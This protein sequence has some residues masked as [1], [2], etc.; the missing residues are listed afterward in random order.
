[1]RPATA[2][3]YAAPAGLSPP[4]RIADLATAAMGA[5]LLFAY[6]QAWVFP[7][8]GEGAVDGGIV[9]LLY[10]P[11]YAAGLALIATAPGS[12]AKGLARQPFLL[13]LLLVAALSIGW[14]IAPDQSGRRVFALVCTTLGGAALAARY[15]WE[16]FAELTAGVFGALALGSFAVAV[17]LPGVGVM[18]EIFPGAWRGLWVEKNA[19]GGNMALGVVFMAGAAILNPRRAWLWWP[20]AAL[21][22]LL[23]LLSTSKTSLLAL[24]IGLAVMVV[25]RMIRQGPGMAVVTVWGALVGLGLVVAVI[26]FASDVVFDVLGKD[27]TLTGRTRIWAAA[28]RQVELRPWTGFGYGA[29]WDTEGAWTPLASIVKEAGFRPL[30]AHSAWVEQWLGM[31]VIGLGLF[32][33]FFLQAWMGA[34]WAMFRG[35]GGYIA[36]P[37]LAVYSLMSITESVA[38]TYND[39]RWVLC[40]AVAVKLFSPDPPVEAR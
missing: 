14:S 6:S 27:A 11:A 29:V 9:R 3:H 19:L 2:A 1:M 7:L 25:V 31:G 30:H 13:L 21:G 20:A 23:I 32:G 36:A 4:L 22:L 17:A 15:R 12:A 8:M 18:S 34:I 10:V 35:S 16:T 37:F 26:L 38:V 5:I 40:V 33:L 28:M 24:L 39:F